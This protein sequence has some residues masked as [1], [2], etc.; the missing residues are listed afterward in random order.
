MVEVSEKLH[1]SQSS[2]TK[3]GVVEGSDLLDGDLLPRWLV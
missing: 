3:H 2:Q 1:L